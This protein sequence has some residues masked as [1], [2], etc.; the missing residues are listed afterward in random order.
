M[1]SLNILEI[2]ILEIIDL[3]VYMI[4]SLNDCNIIYN[5]LAKI[6]NKYNKNLDKSG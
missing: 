4:I 3:L 5:I 1:N 2:I 6:Y